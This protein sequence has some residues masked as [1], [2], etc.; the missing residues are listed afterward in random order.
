[1]TWHGCKQ[2]A[3]STSA[4]QLS[5]PTK[6]YTEVLLLH[7][8]LHFFLIIIIMSIKQFTMKDKTVHNEE[9]EWTEITD[10]HSSLK[11]L[12]GQ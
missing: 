9:G 12:Q 11:E 6:S 10:K 5:F 1:M 3:L 2:L 8:V 4:N 7:T